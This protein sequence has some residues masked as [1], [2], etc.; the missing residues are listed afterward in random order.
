T[1]LCDR[2]LVAQVELR[3]TIDV[4]INTRV[5]GFSLGLEQADLIVLADAGT[6]WVAGSG[7][8]RVPTG[9][10]Q[11]FDEWLADVGV[12]VEGQLFGVYLAKSVT[13]GDSPRVS[14]R[15]RRRF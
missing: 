8:G 5:A 6:A 15:L 14:V 4:G 12:G 3:R 10:V 13:D 11:A 1:A 7:A 2:Q 9:R